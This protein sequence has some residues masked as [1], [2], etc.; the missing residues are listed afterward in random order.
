MK[1]LLRIYLNWIYNLINFLINIIVI[2]LPY[3]SFVSIPYAY[4]AIIYKSLFSVFRQVGL[5]E[6]VDWSLINISFTI[7]SPYKFIKYYFKK[8]NI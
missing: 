8:K 6:F 5:F 1:H 4:H 7:T 3:E 2:I